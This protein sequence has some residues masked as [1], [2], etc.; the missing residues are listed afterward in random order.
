VHCSRN[1]A[2]AAAA[3]DERFFHLNVFDVD[4]HLAADVAAMRVHHL[5]VV[6]VILLTSSVSNFFLLSIRT[7]KLECLPFL[8]IISNQGQML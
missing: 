5:L 7:N 4:E 2:A 1:F 8:A 3:R 6:V